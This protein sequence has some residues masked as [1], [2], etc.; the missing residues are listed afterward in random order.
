MNDHYKI[1]LEQAL[2]WIKENHE[3]VGVI[4]SGS[5][6]RGNPNANSDFDIYVIH[7]KN[8][9]QRIQKYFNGVPCEIFLNSPAHI[10]SYLEAELKNNRPCTAH[11]L[12]TGV[13]Y[14]GE[15]NTNILSLIEKAKQ[16]QYKTTELTEQQV[17]AY[18]YGIATLFE[19]ATDLLET[20]E[21]LTEHIL[22]KL[23]IDIIDFTFR[24]EQKTLPR[25][26]ERLNE[27]AV[28]NPVLA[29]LITNY[30]TNTIAKQ[31]YI[32]AKQ[33]MELLDIPQ[34]F[35]EWTSTQDK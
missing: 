3:P 25:I 22:N 28:I 20:D 33:I 24:K 32:I 9:R 13:V 5:I 17:I 8:F 35:F 4:V 21:I 16:Y 31:K 2:A 19:D 26:K 23:I 11:M 10:H 27:L 6:I 7:E 34:G 15:S 14:L 12:A 30:Y 1:A 18:K 29:G